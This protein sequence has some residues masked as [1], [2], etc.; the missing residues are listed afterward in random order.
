MGTT[1]PWEGLSRRLCSAA[2]LE[3]HKG[4]PSCYQFQ[5]S[6]RDFKCFCLCRCLTRLDPWPLVEKYLSKVKQVPTSCFLALQC[7]W[8]VLPFGFGAWLEILNDLRRGRNL[9]LSRSSGHII[10]SV[11]WHE[12]N[13]VFK[14]LEGIPDGGQSSLGK[15]P[16]GALNFE[17]SRAV[18]LIYWPWCFNRTPP[19]PEAPHMSQSLKVTNLTFYS[20]RF[21]P[22]W[23]GHWRLEDLLF[24]LDVERSAET[25]RSWK[26][27]SRS[28]SAET[29]HL[30]PLGSMFATFV[31]TWRTTCYSCWNTAFFVWLMARG[32]DAKAS[33]TQRHRTFAKPNSK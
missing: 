19:D 2:H 18:E 21:P 24:S 28:W 3:Q 11:F 15:I 27:C 7:Y 12:I 14:D 5:I 9:A 10:R 26:Q 6:T 23:A 33:V 17:T 30:H 32:I 13:A 29:A 20:I 31:P 1:K 8:S 22:C 4:H 16:G 25:A